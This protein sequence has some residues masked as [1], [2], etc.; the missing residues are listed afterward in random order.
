[1]KIVT[2]DGVFHADDVMAY[3]ILCW[4]YATGPETPDGP[5]DITRTRDPE[6]IKSAD[7]VF[8]VGGV[9]DPDKGRFDHHQRE[10][11][12]E[13]PNGIKYSSAG[14]IARHYLAPLLGEEVFAIVDRSL[15]QPIDATD[16]GQRL[17]EP[18]VPGV[19]QFGISQVLGG[20]NPPW[21]QNPGPNSF[22]ALFERAADTALRILENEIQRAQLDDLARAEVAAAPGDETV[23]L[24]RFVPWMN[25]I[26]SRP[27]AMFVVF[28][29][30]NGQWNVQGVPTA[31]GSKVNKV[32]FPAA[33]GGLNDIW[34]AQESG[35]DDAVFCH[36]N[37]FIAGAKTRTGAILL[38]HQALHAARGNA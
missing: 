10:G 18:L 1:M 22:D 35:V 12:G 28:P 13:R 27:R 15:F 5:P 8:D 38:A 32:A 36:R 25:H 37:L 6:V 23:V 3:A 31:P 20:F 7:I 24:D 2:H 29:T 16:N 30:H 14:L 9:Y 26:A 19:F 17:A 4:V 34:L 21:N 11:A 33:W